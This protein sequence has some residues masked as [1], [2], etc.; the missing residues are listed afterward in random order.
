MKLGIMQPYFFPYIGYWQLMNAVDKFVVYDDIQFTKKGWIHRNRFLQ[1]GKD[2][3]F[4]LSLKKDSDYLDIRQRFLAENNKKNVD[5]ILRQ[6]ENTYSKAQNYPQVMEVIQ[7]S[8]L[9]SDDNLFGY[10]MHSLLNIK[11]YLGISTP[12]IVSS[13]LDYNSTLKSQDKVL[14]ICAVLSAESYYNPIGG[15]EL[16]RKSDFQDKGID[17]HFL[18]S[19]DI[20][21]DQFKNEFVPNLSI[22]DVLMFNSVDKVKKL[23]NNFTLF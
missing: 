19:G 22:I 3:M 11:E 2:A 1:N 9:Y 5:K 8:F 23:L 7:A 18:Q 13:T 12:L 16:Y 14:D 20:I 10:I 17:L 6:F 4:S 21:Y 15:T